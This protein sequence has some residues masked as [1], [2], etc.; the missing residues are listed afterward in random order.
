MT[1]VVH[2]PSGTE[3]DLSGERLQQHLLAGWV[4]KNA[5][6]RIIIAGG[7]R[8]EAGT[9]PLRVGRFVEAY[10]EAGGGIF[11]PPEELGRDIIEAEHARAAARRAEARGPDEAGLAFV[12]GAA[13][14][15][16]P[17]NP[18]LRQ[19][20]DPDSAAQ[21]DRLREE[22]PGTALLG[23]FTGFGISLLAGRGIG[24]AGGA[25]R[26]AGTARTALSLLAGPGAASLRA[27]Q[28]AR[29]LVA[30]M[31]GQTP[32]RFA[33]V[34]PA[35]ADVAAQEVVA[36][37]GLHAQEAIRTDAPLLSQQLIADAGMSAALGLGLEAV[38]GA[39][40][41][42]LGRSTRALQRSTTSSEIVNPGRIA[43][44]ESG[45]RPGATAEEVL[46]HFEGGMQALGR[47]PV[48][49]S[50]LMEPI[51]RVN[52]GLS[53]DD[54][55]VVNTK[56][57][58]R[59]FQRAVT[60]QNNDAQ[61][62][63]AGLV[64]MRELD[65]AATQAARDPK[66]YASQYDDVFRAIDEHP[67]ELA[68]AIKGRAEATSE[69]AEA[70]SKTQLHTGTRTRLTKIR[71][72]LDTFQ[73]TAQL[74]Q[75][76]QKSAAEVYAAARSADSLIGDL[77]NPAF[78]DPELGVVVRNEDRE[79][80]ANVRN[81]FRSEVVGNPVWG[82]I[83][84]VEQARGEIFS[85]IIEGWK[86][87]KRKVEDKSV[88]LG[89]AGERSISVSKIATLLRQI[90]DVDKGGDELFRAL[91]D[92]AA[93]VRSGA[94][95]LRK[96]GFTAEDDILRR[97]DSVV[98]KF[99]ADMVEA[100][101]NARVLHRGNRLLARETKMGQAGALG[102]LAL[103]T[104]VGLGTGN[105]IIGGMAVLGSLYANHLFR[106][107]S[108]A[109][110]FGAMR[111]M[112]DRITTRKATALTKLRRRLRSP[113]VR[114]GV[115]ASR[116]LPALIFALNNRK[117]RQEEFVRMREDLLHLQQ[118]PDTLID[119]ISVSTVGIEDMDADL[120][121][122]SRLTAF[123]GFEFLLSH[124]PNT[125][126]DPL[127]GVLPP[128]A[129]E[130]DAFVEKYIGVEDPYSL[131]EDLAEG[132]VTSEKAMAV[133]AVYPDIYTDI[134]VDVSEV[135]SEL[136]TPLPYQYRVHLSTM[137]GGGFDVTLEGQFIASMQNA[138]FQT[139][140]QQEAI[141]GRTPSPRRQA[142]SMPQMVTSTETELQRAIR[143]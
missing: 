77:S 82:P 66:R 102:A 29:G 83:V 18:A 52:I 76:G 1:V 96:L 58:Q 10:Q 80:L 139:Q 6:D 13:D 90:G 50:R 101:I 119:R 17:W 85:E 87:I 56:E 25:G 99:N 45:L 64:E 57:G 84:G 131:L 41:R 28:G 120:A 63:H 15:L 100:T 36:T 135:V 115:G 35:A 94:Q 113:G 55:L 31:V 38:M 108:S 61:N 60:D 121:N 95:E 74:G 72:A 73:E 19:V 51:Q 141:Q 9:R 136:Q 22:R 97:L 134:V 27:G 46:E 104:L 14:F 69:M 123:R 81:A 71:E 128:S 39:G 68:L 118:N 37:A 137:L 44:M 70:L 4:P 93:R 91:V 79:A 114:V 11:I 92:Q 32:G 103:G 105:P 132:S 129:V 138:G 111:N 116:P 62:I 20:T 127:G 78:K 33:S 8:G 59:R 98:D 40:G 142:Q 106:P 130:M 16:A 34:L 7:R 126:Q 140:Q 5:N 47:D 30:G 43:Q 125:P 75:N 88:E 107:G 110:R 117:E 89:E 42:V 143:R 53:P 65:R 122:E 3:L 49:G 86:R 54:A 12:A 109:I 124:M 112:M 67:Q 48:A 21:V 26:A 23:E 133:R 24:A 2:E